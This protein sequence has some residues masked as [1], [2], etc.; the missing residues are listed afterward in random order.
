M[1]QVGLV[2]RTLDPS[3]FTKPLAVQ[4]GV[5]FGAAKFF[6]S[7]FAAI[8]SIAGVTAMLPSKQAIESFAAL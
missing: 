2:A 8:V 7:L 3:P 4:V 5:G 1:V 6:V